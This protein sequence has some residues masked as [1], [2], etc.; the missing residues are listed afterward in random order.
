MKYFLLLL[1]TA[2]GFGACVQDDELPP[3]TQPATVNDFLMHTDG[4]T[5]SLFIEEGVDET[6]SFNPFVF[7]FYPDGTV[8]A[9][10]EVSSIAGNY[11]VFEDDNVT[12]LRMTFPENTPLFELADDWYFVSMDASQIRFEDNGDTIEF[13]R[14]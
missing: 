1:F 3:V 11:L 12:E 5:I 14:Q 2:V 10:E 6:A 13:Q 8:T 7:S 4:L 9:T